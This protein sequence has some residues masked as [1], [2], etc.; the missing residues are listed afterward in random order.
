MVIGT[1]AY[2]GSGQDT[3]ADSFCHRKG[4]LKFS[5]GD[6]IRDIAQRQGL[7]PKRENLQRIREQ[8]DSIYGRNYVPKQAIHKIRL[9][10][11]HNIVITGIRT[12]QEYH[13][14]KQQLDMCLIFVSA[15]KEIRFQRM[16]KRSDEKDETNYSELQKRMDKE[17]KLFDYELLEQYADI[18]YDFNMNLDDYLS[19]EEDILN[20]LLWQIQSVP[21]KA[22]IDI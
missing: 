12:I 19:N 21:S 3:L 8:C 13:I 20:D 4:F 9:M 2:C 1:F 11:K 16:M 22:R 15:A 10:L 7:Q 18:T 17:E 5:L 14:F 6:I